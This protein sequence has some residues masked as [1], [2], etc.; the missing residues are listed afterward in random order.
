MCGSSSTRAKVIRSD[1]YCP[2]LRGGADPRGLPASGRPEAQPLV[3]SA[4][5]DDD[6]TVASV[7]ASRTRDSRK[8]RSSATWDTPKG[9]AAWTIS[10]RRVADWAGAYRPGGSVTGDFTE[11]LHQERA[12]L[13]RVVD[14]DSVSH[15]RRELIRDLGTPDSVYCRALRAA[16]TDAERAEFN[17]EWCTL[18]ADMVQRVAA[19]AASATPADPRSTAVLILASVHGGSR[20]SRLAQDNQ[21][22]DAALSLALTH[23]APTVTKTG[24]ATARRRAAI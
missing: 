9:I 21:L 20:L 16:A 10:S 8:A 1:R 12:R 22:L 6:W 19:N 11:V 17:E 7:S 24:P 2:V 4:A 18:I 3:V 13:A 14:G 5:T 23:L 15:W